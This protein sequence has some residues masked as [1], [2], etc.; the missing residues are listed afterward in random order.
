MHIKHIVLSGGSYHGIQLLGALYEAEEKLLQ[1][2]NIVSVYGTSAG[3]IVLAIWLLRIEKKIVYDFIIERPW[4]KTYLLDS[5]IIA[6]LLTKK[7]ICD[8]NII[9][10]IH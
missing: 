1:F 6:N 5:N 8:K 2:K 9:N 4:Q 7:G 10:E 3:S